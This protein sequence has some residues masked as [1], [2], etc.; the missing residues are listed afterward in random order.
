MKQNIVMCSTSVYA[1]QREPRSTTYFHPLL[2]YVSCSVISR[3]ADLGLPGY[4]SLLLRDF[5]QVGDRLMK[6]ESPRL[7]NSNVLCDGLGMM[8]LRITVWYVPGS[9]YY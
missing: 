8:K 9:E 2:L 1:I 5:N 6:G 7:G 4:E 3:L